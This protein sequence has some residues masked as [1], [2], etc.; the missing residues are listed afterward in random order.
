MTAPHRRFTHSRT[1]I[2]FAAGFVALTLS[3]CAATTAEV[4]ATSEPTEVIQG[5]NEFA[6]VEPD[7]DSV[8]LLPADLAAAG[9]F[10]VVMNAGSAPTKFFAD[11]N[12]TIIGV[13]ADIAR[14]LGKTLGL[15]TTIEDVQFDGIIPALQADRYDVAVSSMAVTEERTA[16]LDMI[17]YAH[18]GSSMLVVAGNP[19]NIS[20]DDLCGVTVAVQQGSIQQAKTIPNLSI[21]MCGTADG[22]V[23]VVLPSQQDA[24]TQLSSGRVEAVI[25][26]TPVLGYAASQAPTRFEI[27]GEINSSA[28]TIAAPKGSDFT[29]A[30]EAAMQ[31]VL[32]LP[33]YQEVM[34]VWGMAN[35]GITETSLHN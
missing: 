16:V 23:Q 14:L 9:E 19:D 28:V 13:N 30:L 1:G 4:A 3:G 8:A 11:D 21:E 35:A 15:T 18:W 5:L 7:V 29:P 32:T 31:H 27:G 25:A 12:E 20:V 33:E 10:T 2:L 6:S 24:V 17:D 26:D 22:I 34:A